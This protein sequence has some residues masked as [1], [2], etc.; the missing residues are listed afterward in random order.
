MKKFIPYLL[1][2]YILS[3][4]FNHSSLIEKVPNDNLQL[5]IVSTLWFILFLII[6]LLIYLFSKSFKAF[7]ISFWII[8]VIFC[9]LTFGNYWAKNHSLYN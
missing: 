9:V 6:P 7:K 3:F 4:A 2:Y 1:S 5:I 8:F